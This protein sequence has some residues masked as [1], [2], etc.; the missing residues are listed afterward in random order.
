MCL[1][2]VRHGQSRCC[3]SSVHT[4]PGAEKM[5]RSSRIC[6]TPKGLCR[7]SEIIGWQ[8]EET[9]RHHDNLSAYR[10]GALLRSKEMDRRAAGAARYKFDHVEDTHGQRLWRQRSNT[11]VRVASPAYGMGNPDAVGVQCMPYPE[12]KRWSEAAAFQQPRNLPSLKTRKPLDEEIP[13]FVPD[14]LVILGAGET[15]ADAEALTDRW[16]NRR[17]GLS[18]VRPEP[19]KLNAPELSPPTRHQS[20]QPDESMLCR[21]KLHRRIL[22]WS[23]SA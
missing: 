3:G 6:A 7:H 22:C 21:Y 17:K 19:P 15:K 9:K 2:R 16:S 1:A 14:N 13:I 4:H 11:V 18:L 12:P 8:T 5:V 23:H 20:L 10:L